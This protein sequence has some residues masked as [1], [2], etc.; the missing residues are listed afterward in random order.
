LLVGKSRNKNRDCKRSKHN[1]SFIQNTGIQQ[2]QATQT[3]K[4]ANTT[5]VLYKIQEYSRNRLQ[6]RNRMTG[7]R[8]PK[9]LNKFIPKARR[10]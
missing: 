2:K 4:E 1:P 7:N 10:N 8:L 6:H 5:Q 9:I 3:A